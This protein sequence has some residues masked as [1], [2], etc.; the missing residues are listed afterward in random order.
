MARIILIAA[1]NREAGERQ[2]EWTLGYK[3]LQWCRDNLGLESEPISLQECI[4]LIPN[5]SDKGN[6]CVFVKVDKNEKGPLTPGVYPSSRSG[7]E[8][9]ELLRDELR[10]AT[11]ATS[12]ILGGIDE[13]NQK[14]SMEILDIAKPFPKVIH[15]PGKIEQIFQDGKEVLIGLPLCGNSNGSPVAGNSDGITTITACKECQSIA[16]ESSSPPIAVSD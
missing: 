6:Q 11:S 12:S 14:H 8:V 3:P 1:A 15:H 2:R 9:K 4:T 16:R 5:P 7:V 10:L 13:S